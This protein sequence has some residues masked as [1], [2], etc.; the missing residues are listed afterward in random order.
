MTVL[1]AYL[2]ANP[3]A[4]PSQMEELYGAPDHLY[5]EIGEEPPERGVVEIDIDGD[6]IPY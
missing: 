2:Y 1:Q 5:R 4:P 3:P 6:E